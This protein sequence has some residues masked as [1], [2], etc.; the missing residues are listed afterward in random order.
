M[1]LI[2]EVMTISQ[3]GT[4]AYSHAR[5]LTASSPYV[6]PGDMV[7]PKT[8]ILIKAQPPPRPPPHLP[9]EC[10][11]LPCAASWTMQITADMTYYRPTVM[12]AVPAILDMSKPTKSATH[13]VQATAEARDYAGAACVLCCSRAMCAASVPALLCCMCSCQSLSPC[14]THTHCAARSVKA[15]LSKKLEDGGGLPAKLFFGAVARKL[16]AV[17]PG[18]DHTGYSSKA[19]MGGPVAIALGLAAALGA[20]TFLGKVRWWITAVVGALAAGVCAVAAGALDRVIIK[21][22]KKVAGLVPTPA[23]T[24]PHLHTHKR[25]MRTVA[26]APACCLEHS[27]LPTHTHAAVRCT[28]RPPCRTG[29]GCWSLA[30]LRSRPRPTCSARRSSVRSPRATAPPRPPAAP[31]SRRSAR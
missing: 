10:P 8:P 5:T 20:G 6:R 25:R 28:P 1:E 21:K 11:V 2:V 7:R 18:G 16:T 29:S 19:G 9:S 4:I 22:V 23:H 13:P 17:A 15:G 14:G 30:A 12:A 27:H 24:C 3:G 26:P 31:R